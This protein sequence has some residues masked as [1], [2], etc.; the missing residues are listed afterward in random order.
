MTARLPAPLWSDSPEPGE[1]WVLLI[2]LAALGLSCSP[3]DLQS[4]FC[5]GASLVAAGKLSCTTWDL[6]PRPRI[7]QEPPALGARNRPWDH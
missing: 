2:Y 5:H 3:W 1:R 7:Q 6:V 4:S